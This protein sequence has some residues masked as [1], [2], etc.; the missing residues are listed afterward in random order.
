M[1]VY[2]YIYM[3]VCTCIRVKFIPYMISQVWDAGRLWPAPR[4]RCV[5]GAEADKSD[6][7]LHEGEDGEEG[8]EGGKTCV[9]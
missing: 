6:E 3:Y 8:E 4:L 1:Y 2:I 5:G 9:W 7:T